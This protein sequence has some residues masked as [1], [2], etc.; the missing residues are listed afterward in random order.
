MNNRFEE[1]WRISNN[2]LIKDLLVIEPNK[3]ITNDKTKEFVWENIKFPPCSCKIDC[4]GMQDITIIGKQFDNVCGCWPFSVMNPSGKQLVYLYEWIMAVKN[5][6]AD[7]K[8]A[9]S[10]SKS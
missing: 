2:I 5:F 9:K 8:M 3:Y 4:K 6:I 7:L 1:G 10:A